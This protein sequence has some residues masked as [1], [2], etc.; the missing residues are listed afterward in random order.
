[1]QRQI[2]WFLV[3]SLMLASSGAWASD[4][5]RD[6][7]A[8]THADAAANY[9]LVGEYEFDGFKIAQY[10][11]AVLAHFSYMLLSDGEC[12]VV[13]PGRDIDT[14]VQAAEQANSKIVGVWL[15]HSHAD[16]VAGHVE[17]AR[18]LQVPLRI[19]AKADAGYEHIGLQESDTLT[20]GDA[21]VKFLETPGHTPDSMCGVVSSK[22]EPARPLAL[23]T[24]DTLFVGSV[25]R[26]DLLGAGMAA[27]TLASMMFDSWTEKLSKLP[28]DALVLPA[29]GAGSLCGARLSDEPASTILQQRVSNPYLQYTSRG[30]F[31]AAIL[32]GLPEAPQYFAHNAAMNRQGPE[33]V[34]W[35][36][37]LLP[38]IAPTA[39]LAD[40]AEYYVIDIREAEPYAA[41]HIPNS[42]NIA[43]RG[44]FEIW[45]G[46]MVPWGSHVVVTGSKAEMREALRRLHRVGYEVKCVDFAAWKQAGL[47]TTRNNMVTPEQ[48]YAQM[49]TPESAIVV[50]V[51]LPQ[52]WM[53]SRIGAVLN[54]PL[55]KLG[56]DWI[57][58]DQSQRVVTVCNSAYRSSLAVGILER[59]GF[60]HA[61]SMAGG[62]DAWI[63]AGLPIDEPTGAE[64]SASLA[65]APTRLAEPID[66]P[67]LNR[68]MLDLPGTFQLVDIRPPAHFEDYHLPGSQNVQIADLLDRP[69]YPTGIGPLIIVDRDGSLALMVAGILSQRSDRPIKAL[70]GGLQSYWESVGIGA[71]ART[72]QPVI[73]PASPVPAATPPARRAPAKP[74]RRRSAGC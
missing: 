10:D 1:M 39:A 38:L 4:E 3:L 28:D 34:D 51:R 6:D 72:A 69:T 62:R 71:A 15:T 40:P 56:Q 29:H 50:D 60:Q 70:V 44:R 52:E 7:E 5:V 49:Q 55:T 73:T 48:L 20:V 36:P 63:A 47:P 19:S 16:F 25:G 9:Q 66:A 18:R 17:F 65:R 13:D 32:D 30:E 46:T 59:N 2:G 42:V 64:S 61:S 8:A 68:L 45:T 57:K 67:A 43:L 37:E 11:L 23:L 27:S 12:L 41:A 24:G 35:N 21:V 31:V 53:A 54:I 22:G 33:L 26:P 58:L 74:K 14:Y